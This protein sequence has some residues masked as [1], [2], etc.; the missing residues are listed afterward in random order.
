MHKLRVEK[1]GL[2]FSEDK[3]E[4]ITSQQCHPLSISISEP[5]VS[6]DKLTHLDSYNATNFCF[7]GNEAPPMCPQVMQYDNIK[8][9]SFL[10]SN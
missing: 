9:R 4:S 2:L 5:F 6:N 10:V 8:L 1:E 3:R 7:A